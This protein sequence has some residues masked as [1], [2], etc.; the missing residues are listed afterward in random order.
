MRAQALAASMTI[1]VLGG[2]LRDVE[3]WEAVGKD[4]R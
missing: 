1:R 3:E 4:G 2:Y